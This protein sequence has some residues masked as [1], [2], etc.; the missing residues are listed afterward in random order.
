MN[1]HDRLGRLERLHLGDTQPP[2][3]WVNDG[4]G[5][6]RRGAEVV[7]EAEFRCRFPD[8]YSFTLDIARARAED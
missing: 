2:A 5:T 6:V 7:T 3:L 1:L 4:H 8:A